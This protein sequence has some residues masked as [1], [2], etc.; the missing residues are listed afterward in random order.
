MCCS[1]CH[2]HGHKLGGEEDPNVCIGRGN[3][4]LV[5]FFTFLSEGIHLD[6]M[7]KEPSSLVS[8]WLVGEVNFPRFFS[9]ISSSQMSSVSNIVIYFRQIKSHE[10]GLFMVASSEEMNVLM[11]Y[12]VLDKFKFSDTFE[13]QISFWYTIF[14]YTDSN[15]LP[16]WA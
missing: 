12:V 5:C 15:S 6:E 4:E 8:G 16:R 1:P 11:Y 7:R 14:S 10:P 2:T 9:R 13:Y 3:L